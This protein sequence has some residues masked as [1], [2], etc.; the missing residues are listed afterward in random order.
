M[1]QLCDRT[2]E[3]P[4]DS[5]GCGGKTTGHDILTTPSGIFSMGSL[6][7]RPLPVSVEGEEAGGRDESMLPTDV[8]W[9]SSPCC[10]ERGRRGQS[11]CGKW[12]NNTYDALTCLC[13]PPA[14]FMSGEECDN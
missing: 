14:E 4:L 8:L 12:V 7:S 13:F 1:E 6:L 11:G 9:V 5:A 10:L 3:S 2:S